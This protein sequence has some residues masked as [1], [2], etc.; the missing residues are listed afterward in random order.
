MKSTKLIS[1]LLMFILTL[2]QLTGCKSP[3]PA[4]QSEQKTLK[5][6]LFSQGLVPVMVND[7]WGYLN[8]SGEIAI[9]PQFDFCFNFTED[10]LA[11]VQLHHKWGYINTS[12]DYV[13][14]PKFYPYY[15]TVNSPYYDAFSFSNGLACVNLEGKFG[16]IDTHGKFAIEPKYDAGGKFNENG[17]AQAIWNGEPGYLDSTGNFV[18]KLPSDAISDISENMLVAISQNEKYGY[19]D[20]SG[21]LI[22]EAKFN[23]AYDFADNGLACVCEKG[24]WG[25][26]DVSGNF[27]IEPQF[28]W[29]NSFSNGLAEV[30]LD[31]KKGYI[32]ISG[33]FVLEPQF[34][35]TS[36]FTQSGFAYVGISGKWKIINQRGETVFSVESP[37]EPTIFD[38]GYFVVVTPDKNYAIVDENGTQISDAYQQ[39]KG[40]AK[41]CPIAKCPNFSINTSGYCTEHQYLK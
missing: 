36:S 37:I 11:C 19:A 20:A 39:I 35:D 15:E 17:W 41:L 5:N 34:D 18:T 1:L 28:Q 31:G 21:N 40:F 10:G 29:A 30:K 7:K 38:D 3:S 8:Q 2:F 22:I 33:N 6:P 23:Y 27:V 32:D 25:F 14:E 9:E 13:V 24:K 4:N 12:G 26:I 16:Y